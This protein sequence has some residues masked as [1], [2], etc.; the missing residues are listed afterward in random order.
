MAFGNLIVVI[1]AEAKAFSSQA[2]EF[3]LFAGLMAVD[4]GI[5]IILAIKYKYVETNNN[6]EPEEGH[7]D[8]PQKENVNGFKTIDINNE[9]GDGVMN[10]AFTED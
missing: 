9:K 2:A 3:F 8:L 5:F 6:N 7:I 4:M 1:I 10:T